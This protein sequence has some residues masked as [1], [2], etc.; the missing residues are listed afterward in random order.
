MKRPLVLLVTLILACLGTVAPVA[1][2][3]GERAAFAKVS[4]WGSGWEGRFTVTN[5]GTTPIT[6]WRVEFDLPA[7]TSLGS[8][9]D[10][11][12]TSA[13]ATTRSPTASTTAASPP[14]RGDL[15]VPRRRPGR[16]AELPGQRRGL[17]RRAPTRSPAC[18]G[19]PA[20][21]G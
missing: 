16:A 17:R 5:G 10:A 1:S 9:W 2:A 14:A 20:A 6:S 3:A 19:C 4:D 8:Y 12:L 13:A 11:L 18:P 21:C 15:R 7:G